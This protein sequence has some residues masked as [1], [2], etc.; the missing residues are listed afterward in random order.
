MSFTT[1]A[2][3]GETEMGRDHAPGA[4]YS[5]GGGSDRSKLEMQHDLTSWSSLRTMTLHCNVGIEM[6]EGTIRLHAALVVAMIESVDLMVSSS[7]TFR[8]TTPS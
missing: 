5:R 1:K 8:H 3:K 2:K 6:I 4:P 7:W